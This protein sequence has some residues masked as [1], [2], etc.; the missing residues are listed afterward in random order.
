MVI[1]SIPLKSN[2]SNLFLDD[3]LMPFINALSI[4]SMMKPIKKPNGMASQ[5]FVATVLKKYVHAIVANAQVAKTVMPIILCR[6]LSTTASANNSFSAVESHHK[7]SV[8]FVGL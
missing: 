7:N 2:G 3:L 4:V 5:L 6:F 1:A 8:I